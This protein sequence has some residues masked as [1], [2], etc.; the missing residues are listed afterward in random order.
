MRRVLIVLS[1]A[2]VS[3]MAAT[4]DPA[5]DEIQQ[6]LHFVETSHCHFIRNGEA[7]QA[8]EA[9]AHL[10][11]KLDYLQRRKL[12]ASSEDFIERA[13]SRSSISG[14]TY[15]VSCQGQH[16]RPNPG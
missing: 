1:F 12:I 8:L 2:T 7:Y 10:Q 16:Q 14:R 9:R 5:S 3:A 13:A 6:L 4:D 15:E 11:K